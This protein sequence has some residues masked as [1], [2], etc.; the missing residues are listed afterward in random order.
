MR[1]SEV[2]EWC[3]P[4]PSILRT[5]RA[6][7][8]SNRLRSH[9]QSPGV[10]WDDLDA[11]AVVG[12]AVPVPPLSVAASPYESAS[13]NWSRS[14][15]RSTGLPRETGLAHSNW[16]MLPLHA[17]AR[18]VCVFLRI[19]SAPAVRLRSTDIA[20]WRTASGTAPQSGATRDPG[21]EGGLALDT[22]MVSSLASPF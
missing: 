18:S 22:S 2:A 12:T 7:S 20:A 19:P 13:A 9:T 6:C 3:L 21:R 8:S 11:W 1:W 10:V 5:A 4:N 15:L 14:R 16:E 17:A